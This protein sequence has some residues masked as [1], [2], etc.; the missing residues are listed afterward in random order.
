M[1]NTFVKMINR[2]TKLVPIGTEYSWL[3]EKESL[4][5]QTNF[6]IDFRIRNHTDNI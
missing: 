4:K 2:N 1:L 5:N 6:Q 3:A